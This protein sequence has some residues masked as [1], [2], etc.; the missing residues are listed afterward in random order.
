MNERSTGPAALAKLYRFLAD[1]RERRD[2][3]TL[4][5]EDASDGV[6]GCRTVMRCVEVCPKNVRPADGIRA[7]RRKLLG[8]K[9]RG[10]LR[11]KAE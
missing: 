6:W 8:Q 5:Q 2:D 10:L 11:R 9:I 1:S 3:Q 7:V 4:K